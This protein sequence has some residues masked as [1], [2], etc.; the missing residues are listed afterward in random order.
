MKA[1]ES[2]KDCC[3]PSFHSSE[4]SLQMTQKHNGHEGTPNPK[5]RHCNVSFHAY[6]LSSRRNFYR[7][8]SLALCGQSDT[9]MVSH[10]LGRD[11]LVL[12]KHSLAYKHAA[13]LSCVR[14]ID[15]IIVRWEFIVRAIERQSAILPKDD[16]QDS[17]RWDRKTCSKA[18][19][20]WLGRQGLGRNL[21]ENKLHLPDN[22]YCNRYPPYCLSRYA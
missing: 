12:R 8:K 18:I 19:S 20:G 22:V 3:W 13:T 16:T 2:S 10:H 15:I 11:G 7:S 17:G 4:I 6:F 21:H 5:L 9:A 14:S 1:F